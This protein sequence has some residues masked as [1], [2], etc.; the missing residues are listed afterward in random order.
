MTRQTFFAAL[1]A[2]LCF[3]APMIAEDAPAIEMDGQM[4]ISIGEFP[5]DGNGDSIVGGNAATQNEYPWMARLESGG[6]QWCGGALVDRWAVVT[7]A[8]CVDGFNISRVLLGDH[9]ISTHQNTE[10]W[11]YVQDAV[12]HPN[13]NP[14]VGNPFDNDIA[15]LLL[16]GP[17]RITAG[18][19]VEL[20][21]FG[22][23][24]GA[25]ATTTVTGWGR[26]AWNTGVSD[27]LREVDIDVVANGACAFGVT[28][29][30]ICAGNANEGGCNADSGGPMVDNQDRLVGVVS[31]GSQF[32]NSSTVFTRVDNYQGWIQ[33]QINNHMNGYVACLDDCDDEYGQCMQEA[34]HWEDAEYCEAD[35][36]YC[37]RRCD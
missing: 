12:I 32:C 14:N 6:Q 23:A 15:V 22:P 3:A 16:E 30:M 2:M 10:Q 9:R 35:Y 1:G 36:D 21:G 31:H 13:Y 11:R 28:N 33:T 5:V 26:T 18:S 27:V 8:H 25:G 24:P 29:N 7:A 37:L 17:A 34:W 19:Q 20:I 4:P